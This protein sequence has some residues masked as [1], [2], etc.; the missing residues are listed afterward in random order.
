MLRTEG[1]T[2]LKMTMATILSCAAAGGGENLFIL[3]VKAE[4]LCLRFTVIVN[5]D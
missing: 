4:T 3:L 1:L 2:W 5:S